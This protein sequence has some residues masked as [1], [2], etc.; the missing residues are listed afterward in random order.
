MKLCLVL[1]A[2]A[3][4]P[5]S[6]RSSCSVPP[7]LAATCRYAEWR[8][9]PPLSFMPPRCARCRVRACAAAAC[10]M[11]AYACCHC[12]LAAAAV[13]LL[14]LPLLADSCRCLLWRAARRGEG[15][16][17][18]SWLCQQQ[19]I[20]ERVWRTIVTIERCRC[21]YAHGIIQVHALSSGGNTLLL[22]VVLAF[23]RMAYNDV[24]SSA[25]WTSPSLHR[26]CQEGFHD[27]LVLMLI[28]IAHEW[29]TVS[30][31]N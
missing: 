9:P 25:R 11:H 18:V 14:L 10:R 15:E 1:P 13:C 27:G 19:Y 24:Q 16:K 31:H 6:S 30:S 5:S 4:L 20:Q 2:R 22:C 17:R 23:A 28:V 8:A 12:L 26:G 29:P 7:W 21:E 3:L